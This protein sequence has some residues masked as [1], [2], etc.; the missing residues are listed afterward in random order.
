VA[1]KLRTARPED[2]PAIESLIR[3][4]SLPAMEVEEWLDTFFVLEEA[5]EIVACAGI[6][7][8]GD[9]AVLRS[10]VIAESIRGTGEGDRL[11][12]HALDWAK[13]DG[14]KRC[15]LFTMTAEAFF[16]RYGF[17]RCALE[18]FEEAARQSWQW[19][20]VSGQEQL[21]QMLTPMKGDL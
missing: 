14:A 16:N 13:A 12:Q 19:R 11:T 5:G 17:E 15:Y 1:P 21:R 3:S 9:C 6:E 18:D 20:G 7:R 4:E 2:I 10:V 8:Y